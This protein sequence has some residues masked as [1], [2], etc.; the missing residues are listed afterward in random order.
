MLLI[1]YPKNYKQSI[2]TK[3]CRCSTKKV[4]L[5]ISQ[6]I[7]E[8]TCVGVSFSINLQAFSLQLYLKRDSS[9]GVFL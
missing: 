1:I 7:Q 4:F 5:K 6:H 8:N 2:L 9:T 3:L